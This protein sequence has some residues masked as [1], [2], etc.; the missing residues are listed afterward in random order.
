MPAEIA[1]ILRSETAEQLEVDDDAR[2]LSRVISFV[3]LR[4]RLTSLLVRV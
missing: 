4:Q 2:L 3:F 1:K